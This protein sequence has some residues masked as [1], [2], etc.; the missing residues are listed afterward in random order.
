M[1][2]TSVPWRPVAVTG[3]VDATERPAYHSRLSQLSLT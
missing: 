1:R 3:E 2:A